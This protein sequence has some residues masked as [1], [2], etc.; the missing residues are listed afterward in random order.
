VEAVKVVVV[1]AT[2]C[3]TLTMRVEDVDLELLVLPL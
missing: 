1:V 3:P 2:L